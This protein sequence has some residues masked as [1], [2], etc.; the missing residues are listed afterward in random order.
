MHDAQGL[1]PFRAFPRSTEHGC[2]R[3]AVKPLLG[4]LL[5]VLS[6]L[7]FTMMAASLKFVSAAYPT[8]ELVFFRSFF[9]LAPLLVWLSW[10]GDLIG[11]VRTRDM[12]GHLTRG[13]IGSAGMFSSFVALVYLSL[14]DAVAIGYAASL[15]VVV[16]AAMLLKEG[17]RAYRWSAVEVG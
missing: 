4:I 6:A 10:Q 13:V 2:V 14:H 3:R 7:A 8:G 17:V 16:H 12:R 5:K 15:I 1:A 9:A 11:A